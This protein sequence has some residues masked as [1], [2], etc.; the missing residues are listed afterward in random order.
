MIWPNLPV[1]L[2]VPVP[3]EALTAPAPEEDSAL[4]PS[5]I[6]AAPR[7]GLRVGLRVALRVGLPKVALRVGAVSRPQDEFRMG[8]GPSCDGNG[9]PRTKAEISAAIA[10]PRAALPR[11]VPVAMDAGMT[12]PA[13]AKTVV[14]IPQGVTMVLDQT[15]D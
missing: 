6:A 15:I 3:R 12:G 11:G 9:P 7:V 10:V 5:L 1:P 8:I 14:G 2:A 13:I 4:G